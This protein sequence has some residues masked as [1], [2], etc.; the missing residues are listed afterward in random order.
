MLQDSSCK[1]AL[2]PGWE[3]PPR[4]VTQQNQAPFN[5]CHQIRRKNPPEL[6]PQPR[7]EQREDGTSW[8]CERAS[9]GA[10][11]TANTSG[12]GRGRGRAGPVCA[13][14]HV[15]ALIGSIGI[16][17]SGTRCQRCS[18]GNSPRGEESVP[19]VPPAPLSH[20]AAPLS[21]RLP[22]FPRSHRWLPLTH[23]RGH[24]PVPRFPL[25]H[26][27]RAHPLLS[28]PHPGH[29]WALGLA[30]D[31]PSSPEEHPRTLRLGSS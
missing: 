20:P 6:P 19:G 25:T 4:S 3:R 10:R 16:G 2:A 31:P 13:E 29:F 14:L 5:T 1:P 11:G 28:N 23:A 27:S 15:R 12:W 8:R 9:L 24:S 18:E 30:W 26:R 21:H 22:P 17:S 7:P